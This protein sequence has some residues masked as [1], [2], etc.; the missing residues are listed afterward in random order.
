LLIGTGAVTTTNH[1]GI[2]TQPPAQGN[3]VVETFPGRVYYVSTDQSGNFRVGEFFRIDQ[4]TGTATLNAN[5]FNLAGLTSL[6][7]GSIGAQLG[8]SIN[9]FSSDGT[10]AGDSNLAVPTEFAVK[11]YVDTGLDNLT[12]TVLPYQIVTANTTS[13]PVVSYVKY[14]VISTATRTLTLPASPVDGSV[15]VVADGS[16]FTSFNT[17]IAR[18]GKTIGGLAENLILDVI[19]SRVE[20]VYYNN[21]WKIFY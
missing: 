11:T 7:L 20:L 21:D 1:P 15:V 6:R 8:E 16:N 17:T 5:A 18:N 10:L 3:E 12:N 2:P 14:L 19:G 13:V 9:E 4:A